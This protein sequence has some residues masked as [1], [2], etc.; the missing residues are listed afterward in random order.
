MNVLFLFASFF[1]IALK[2]ISPLFTV[3]PENV[4]SDSAVDT[5]NL[6]KGNQ[7]KSNR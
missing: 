7:I 1:S 5:A 2:L 3:D 4:A 6:P